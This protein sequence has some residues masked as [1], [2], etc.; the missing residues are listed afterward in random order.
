MTT[1]VFIVSLCLTSVLVSQAQA[2][3]LR[4][5]VQKISDGDTIT[6]QTNQDSLTIRLACIDAPESD[7]PQGQQASQRLQQLIPIGT[8]IRLNIVDTDRYGR[9]VAEVYKGNNLVNLWMVQEGQSLV[10][11]KYLANCPDN[12][13]RLLDAE[14]KAQRKQL[15]FWGLPPKS[16]I[17]PWDWRR[18][19]RTVNPLPQPTPN[20]SNLPACVNSDCNCS[21]FATQADAQ[22]V[23]EAFSGDPH[24]LDSNS[25]GVACESLP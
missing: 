21:D 25:D 8:Q 2:E 11:R 3:T 5:K 9:K 15:G 17:F 10:Y 24:R 18:G 19:I 4:G 14:V 6:V 20:A 22:R 7:A 12:A 23:L 1:K 16:Q 13:Q